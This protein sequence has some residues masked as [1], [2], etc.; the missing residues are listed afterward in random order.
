MKD[1]NQK[2][3]TTRGCCYSEQFGCYH[4]FPSQF[5]YTSMISASPL[6]I[7]TQQINA[8][9]VPLRPMTPLGETS[10]LLQF[11]LTEVSD[12]RLKIELGIG[13]PGTSNKDVT[14]DGNRTRRYRYE[15]DRPALL[16]RVTDRTDGRLLLTSARGPLIASERYFEWS[17]HLGTDILLGLGETILKQR[18]MKKLL[19][20]NENNSIVP[21]IIGFG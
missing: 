10:E 11:R 8:L 12:H 2:M 18:P 13:I 6:T 7:S 15:I 19:L 5:V 1:I 17:L 3:C 20:V 21:Y 9:L 4:F 14:N 16:I